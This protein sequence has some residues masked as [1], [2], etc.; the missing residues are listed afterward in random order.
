MGRRVYTALEGAGE[1]PLAAGPPSYGASHSTTKVPLS[2]SAY[3][4]VQFQDVFDLLRQVRDRSGGFLRDDLHLGGVVFYR[5]GSSHLVVG[6]P[7]VSGGEVPDFPIVTW[8]G[9]G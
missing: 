6:Y 7:G 3:M 9:V 1:G 2:S 5:P 8:F 4:T